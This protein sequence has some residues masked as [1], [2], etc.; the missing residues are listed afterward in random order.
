M[1]GAECSAV[2]IDDRVK[3]ER[4]VRRGSFD[5][6]TESSMSSLIIADESETLQTNVKLLLDVCR[7]SMFF[8]FFA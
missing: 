5:A 6:M 1:D 2:Y 8:F 7:R 4:W 3:A